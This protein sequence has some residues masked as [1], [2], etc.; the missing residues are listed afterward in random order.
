MLF[1]FIGA[2]DSQLK[3]FLAGVCSMKF[4]RGQ[5]FDK[6]GFVCKYKNQ[7]G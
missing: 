4:M 7:I 5:S 2:I 3:I 6:I 1:L